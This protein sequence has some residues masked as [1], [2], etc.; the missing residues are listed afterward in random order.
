MS[1]LSWPESVLT[2]AQIHTAARELARRRLA[3]EQGPVL[4]AS[5][6]PHNL[7]DAFAIQ[8]QVAALLGPV[9]GW[10][11]GLSS[12]DEQ[13]QLKIVAAPLYQSELQQGES[14]RLWPSTARLARV[15]PE[16]AY[17]LLADLPAAGDYGDAVVSQSFGAP[18]LALELIQSRYAADS[19][20]GYFDQ[21]ADGLFN[22]GLWLGAAVTNEQAAFPLHLQWAT[23]LQ[24]RPA[25]HPNPHPRAPLLPFVRLLH[26]RG[27]SLQAGQLLIT[28]SFAGVLELPLQQ[29]VQWQFGGE[30]AFSLQFVSR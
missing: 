3:G 28:G 16:Y 29:Q 13:G 4:A 5:E 10:K 1:E 24:T 12:Q 23:E 19:G 8:Q 2:T 9:I 18:R 20:A 21:L 6:R 27:I 25:S 15:E 22:Q 7:A 17:P 26:S 30:T 11:C 14:C